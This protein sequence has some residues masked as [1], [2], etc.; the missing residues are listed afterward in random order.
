M[1]PYLSILLFLVASL[2]AASGIAGITRGWVLP[3][4]RGRVHHPRRY[5]WGQL[6]CAAALGA[7]LVF[8]EFPVDNQIRYDGSLAASVLLLAGLLVMASCTRR[9]NRAQ[10]ERPSEVT[11]ARTP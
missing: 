2:Y 5:G 8:R 10:A 9:G 7:L 11:E 4:N 6:V 1:N 3:G